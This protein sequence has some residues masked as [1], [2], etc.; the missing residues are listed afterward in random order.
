[1]RSLWT[2]G[3]LPGNREPGINRLCIPSKLPENFHLRRF[4]YPFIDPVRMYRVCQENASSIR[5][6]VCFPGEWLRA[7]K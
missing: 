3:T 1:M 2:V 5:C 4:L 7:R 6:G